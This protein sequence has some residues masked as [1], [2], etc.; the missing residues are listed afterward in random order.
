M[1]RDGIV[2]MQ[3]VGNPCMSSSDSPIQT[4]TRTWICSTKVQAA[5]W[6]T[7]QITHARR[8]RRHRP[9]PAHHGVGTT[10]HGTMPN[11]HMRSKLQTRNVTTNNHIR[12]QDTITTTTTTTMMAVPATIG[13]WACVAGVSHFNFPSVCCVRVVPI[14][15]VQHRPAAVCWVASICQFIRLGLSNKY[16]VLLGEIDLNVRG[17]GTLNIKGHHTCSWVI[18]Q[19]HRTPPSSRYGSPATRVSHG[20]EAC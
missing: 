1:Q 18:L 2:A 11:T 6:T 5:A 8:G 9:R 19:L 13:V 7:D 15:N 17:W 16:Q 12:S 10:H 3:A 4:G 14:T 20:L